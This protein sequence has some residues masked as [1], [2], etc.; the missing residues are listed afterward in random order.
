[1]SFGVNQLSF[2]LKQMSLWPS[3]NNISRFYR[4]AY[5]N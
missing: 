1:M 2:G 3:D 5:G 4:V